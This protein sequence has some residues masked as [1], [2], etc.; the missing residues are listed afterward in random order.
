M[1]KTLLYSLLTG[2][3]VIGVVLQTW[4]RHLVPGPST[5]EEIQ[6]ESAN[7]ESSSVTAPLLD[8]QSRT[9][10]QI[11]R[12]QSQV[13]L[14]AP[15]FFKDK[16][17]SF[18]WSED[19]L[20]NVLGTIKNSYAATLVEEEND[21]LLLDKIVVSDALGIDSSKLKKSL[22]KKLKSTSNHA[23][24]LAL[25]LVEG[26]NKSPPTDAEHEI[27]RDRLG[28]L[29]DV[30]LAKNDPAL[31]GALQKQQ[32]SSFKTFFII[33]GVVSLAGFISLFSFLFYGFKYLRGKLQPSLFVAK[34]ADPLIEVFCL[35][36]VWFIAG[37]HLVGWLA[38]DE[39]VIG[40]LKF[41]G[42]L[43]LSSL[44][45]LYWP[46]L[47]GYNTKELLFG[48]GFSFGKF[49]RDLLTTPWA[50]LA[51]LAPFIVFMG[52]YTVVLSWLGI[53]LQSASHPITP[54]LGGDSESESRFPWIFFLAAIC[55]PIV[56]EVMFRGAL[57][58]WLRSKLSI[59]P[60]L[61]ISGFIFALVHP[62]GPVGVVPLTLIGIFFAALREWRGSFTTPILAHAIHNGTI[63][64]VASS[65]PPELMGI[66]A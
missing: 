30:L 53:D 49:F 5:P 4:E 16:A 10:R 51:S 60:C 58:G 32:A 24:S 15:K 41:Q 50:Y 28:S 39:S 47:R 40:K 27:I 25:E 22:R 2:T 11:F 56:E 34:D 26:T 44:L 13:Y 20:Q 8:P 57:Y 31:Q 54:I 37:S 35:Y 42:G 59:W 65:V 9:K 1:S 3:L 19:Q 48:K 29:A 52:L 23:E 45:L 33:I 18:G 43:V 7:G 6:S 64:Y 14:G 17:K 36:L 21:L 62:Q 38:A 46:Y 55:A 12:F 66:I 63:V 61:L